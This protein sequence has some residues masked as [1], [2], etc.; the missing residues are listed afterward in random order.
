ME[1]VIS[2]AAID[3]EFKFAGQ[4]LFVDTN[5]V[6]T[7]WGPERAQTDALR[8]LLRPKEEEMKRFLIARAL[9]EVKAT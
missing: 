5:G 4:C 6:V 7:W 9:R 8:D 1:R 2:V 3:Q